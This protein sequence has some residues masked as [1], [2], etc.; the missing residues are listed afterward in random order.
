MTAGSDFDRTTEAQA[1]LESLRKVWSAGEFALLA[2]GLRPRAE[3]ASAG[4]I[5]TC[6]ATCQPGNAV[7]DAV[8]GTVTVVTRSVARNTGD[9]QAD[10]ARQPTGP[11]EP[12]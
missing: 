10:V 1:F 9:R 8:Q 11:F 6:C 12:K 4:P 3:P 2:A 7:R 5:G